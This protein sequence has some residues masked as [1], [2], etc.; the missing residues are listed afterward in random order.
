MYNTRVLLTMT[1]IAFISSIGQPAHKC[2]AARRSGKRI[3]S[4]SP[5]PLLSA[6]PATE[7]NSH[8][9]GPHKCNCFPGRLP[10]H[11]NDA[12]CT[13]PRVRTVSASRVVIRLASFPARMN[14]FVRQTFVD[15]HSYQICCNDSVHLVYRSS[16][17]KICILCLPSADSSK[18]SCHED[19]RVRISA[20]SPDFLSRPLIK[21]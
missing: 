6:R 16:G 20:L 3:D 15:F 4:C 21:F 18:V 17:H 14:P 11:Q 13:I 19:C 10:R 5:G 9:S 7:V 1:T 2:F 12:I 8:P